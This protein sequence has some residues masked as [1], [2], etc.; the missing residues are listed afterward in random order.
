MIMLAAII[1]AAISITGP[2]PIPYEM[3]KDFQPL[4]ASVVALTAA[5]FAYG[6]ANKRIKFD[7]EEAD[8]HRTNE[9]LALFLRVRAAMK[10]TLQD[11]KSALS[12]ISQD[13]SFLNQSIEVRPIHLAI[14][15]PPELEEA[16]KGI[17][18]M[19]VTVIDQIEDLKRLLPLID[20][21]MTKFVDE[22][23]TISFNKDIFGNKTSRRVDDYL[24]LHAMRCTVVRDRCELLIDAL[25][26]ELPLLQQRF[27]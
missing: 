19:P 20:G 26:R 2:I 15:N 11:A 4:I 5:L 12:I 21:E 1:V 8:R 27:R 16:W 13:A 25:D 3:I 9:Q 17:H 22:K 6:A 14:T 10:H 18:L 23:W 7:R 24:T